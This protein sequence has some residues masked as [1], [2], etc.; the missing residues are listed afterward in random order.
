MRADKVQKK[1]LE[2]HSSG[3]PFL[4]EWLVLGNPQKL[5]L[6]GQLVVG[7]LLHFISNQSVCVKDTYL[8]STVP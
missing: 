8:Y 4:I 7:D 2:L 3:N 5:Q 1:S 6:E